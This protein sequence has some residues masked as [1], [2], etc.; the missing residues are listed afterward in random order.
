MSKM[1]TIEKPKG[2]E[3]IPIFEP[4]TKRMVEALKILL[5]SSIL[6][7]DKMKLAK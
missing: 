4:D 7:M 6:D 1:A 5:N 3:Y 2:F